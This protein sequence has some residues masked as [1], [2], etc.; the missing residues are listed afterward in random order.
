MEFCNYESLSWFLLLGLDN[1]EL[2]STN[3]RLK[4]SVQVTCRLL[5]VILEESN[6]EE[7]QV[8]WHPFQQ[9]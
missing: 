7:L 2:L 1:F 3:S 5:G 8:V 9:S 4:A 6:P